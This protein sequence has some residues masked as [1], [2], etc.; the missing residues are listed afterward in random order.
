[1]VSFRPLRIGVLGTPSLNGGM[2]IFCGGKLFPGTKLSNRPPTPRW[3]LASS[4]GL[5][6][7]G[8]LGT[9]EGGGVR[10]HRGGSS[11]K[12]GEK[13]HGTVK[14]VLFL[15]GFGRGKIWK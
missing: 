8:S 14:L 2:Y 10:D 1:M 9:T 11:H 4:L 15:E 3:P 6:K 13:Q 12:T 5:E 7:R